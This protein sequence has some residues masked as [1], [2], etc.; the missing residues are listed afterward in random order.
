MERKSTA[1]FTFINLSEP[2]QSRDKTLKKIVRSN[3]MRTYRQM[4]KQKAIIERSQ[5]ARLDTDNSKSPVLS[6]DTENHRDWPAQGGLARIDTPDASQLKTR[7]LGLETSRDSRRSF[8]SSHDHADSDNNDDVQWLTKREL[9]LR[10][11]PLIENSRGDPFN[12]YPSVSSPKYNDYVLNHCKTPHLRERVPRLVHIPTLGNP[13]SL[14]LFLVTSVMARRYFPSD[15]GTE[16]NP[17]LKVW[18]PHAMADPVLFLATLNVSAIHLDILQ[19]QYSNPITLAHKGETI[20]LINARLGDPVESL[21]NE[22][23]ASVV[24]LA[25]MEVYPID[26]LLPETF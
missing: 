3:A 11:H 17:L 6:I 26:S 19:G 12:V 13:S 14:S 25:A 7:P 1:E 22:T 8:S 15:P 21:T 9:N 23:I 2:K 4:E 10:P 20:R 24:M 5:R 16:N 18:I